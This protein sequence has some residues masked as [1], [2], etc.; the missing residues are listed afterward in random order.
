M[1]ILFPIILLLF[2]SSISA[3]VLPEHSGSWYNRDQDGH[4]LNIEVIDE[5]RTIA[6]WYTYDFAGSPIWFLFDGVNVDNRVEATVYFF[7]NM[8]WGQFDPVS[9]NRQEL[10]TATIEFSDCGH[11]R[12]TYSMGYFGD[13]EIPLERLTHIAGMTCNEVGGLAGDWLATIHSDGLDYWVETT[14]RDNGTFLVS[15]EL[16]CI[17]EGQ[18]RVVDEA[19]GVLAATVGT[20]TC[21]WKVPPFE[22][23]GIYVEPYQVCNSSGQCQTHDAAMGFEGYAIVYPGD[24]DPVSSKVNLRFVRPID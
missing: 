7:E 11:A 15:D 12:L 14:V 23:T 10:G 19:T 1:K 9:I 21:G 17:W 4:G 8:F 2:W 6:Y 16:A 5:E 20:E 18:I 3:Q 24:S 22:M 13:G